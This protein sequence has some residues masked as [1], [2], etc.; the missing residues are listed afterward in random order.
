MIRFLEELLISENDHVSYFTIDLPFG[1]GRG[2]YFKNTLL[3][4]EYLTAVTDKNA[5]IKENETLFGLP[6]IDSKKDQKFICN[7]ILNAYY[8]DQ[9]VNLYLKGTPFQKKIWKHLAQ[10]KKG[11]LISYEE[12]AE[13][14]ATRN[15]VRAVASAVAKNRITLLLPCHRVIYKNGNYGRYGW[16]DELK[17]QLIKSETESV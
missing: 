2:L 14:C 17:I 6:V 9:P 4:L 10:I 1:P 12:F 5:Y 7:E 11:S 8:N 15:A 13:I 3:S 16:G